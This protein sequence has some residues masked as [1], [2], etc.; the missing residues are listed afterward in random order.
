MEDLA[1]RNCRGETGAGPQ[2]ATGP[3]SFNL[4]LERPGNQQQET[5]GT[6]QIV[7]QWESP[8]LYLNTLDQQDC[9]AV[10]TPKHPSG[11]EALN[12]LHVPG[13]EKL[14]DIDPS[15][16]ITANSPKGTLEV[17]PEGQ[18]LTGTVRE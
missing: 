6:Q 16:V 14:V 17:L 2:E 8:A 12:S 7:A 15:V 10:E 9:L 3:S 18:G 4:C 1:A 13:L 11:E 5:R